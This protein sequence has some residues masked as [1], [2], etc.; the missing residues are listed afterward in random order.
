MIE[1][2]DS[3]EAHR[4]RWLDLSLAVAT[5]TVIAWGVL[6]G[7]W[8]VFIVMA[9]FWFE[10][11]VI[12]AFNVAKMLTSGA[13]GAALAASVFTAA[14]FSI[15]YGLFTAVHGIFVAA[16]FGAQDLGKGALDGG[17]FPPLLHM[18]DRLLV[19]RDAWMAI[20]ALILMHAVGFIQWAIDSR[21]QPTPLPALMRAPYGRIVVLHVTLIASGFLVQVLQA[22]KVGALLLVGQRACPSVIRA[23]RCR[24]QVRLQGARRRTVVQ[25]RPSR[26]TPQA[27]LLAT[28]LRDRGGRPA[29]RRCSSLIWAG[30][31]ALLV[32]SPA[33]RPPPSHA[34]I[35]DGQALWLAYDLA[36]LTRAARTSGALPESVHEQS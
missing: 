14:F 8:S 15:H 7:G 30:Q 19:D 34:R 29:W 4:W 25:L 1:A 35:T 26:A 27:G 28:T 5:A 2:L 16:L 11:V 21:G 13:R 33:S 36:T 12:G 17:L 24:Q 10:N 31:T 3:E 20:A 32:P 22:P 18:V 9:L 23:M 6:I